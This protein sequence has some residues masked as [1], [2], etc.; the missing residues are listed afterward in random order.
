MTGITSQETK[1]VVWW[2]LLLRRLLLDQRTVHR[3]LRGDRGGGKHWSHLRHHWLTLQAEGYPLDHTI[4]HH[5]HHHHHNH[6]H[7]HHFV[8]I[9]D[10]KIITNI[11]KCHS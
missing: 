2:Q 3:R 11:K 9:T 4:N 5:H 7:H 6:H 10:I 8:D 1:R